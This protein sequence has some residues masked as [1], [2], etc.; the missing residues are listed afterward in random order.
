[1]VAAIRERLFH[2]DYPT[3]LKEEAKREK[4]TIFLSIS[5]STIYGEGYS[6]YAGSIHT[7]GYKLDTESFWMANLLLIPSPKRREACAKKKVPKD[8]IERQGKVQRCK[9]KRTVGFS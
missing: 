5:I 7:T 9:G 1:M 8:V 2:V 6:P 3:R 4:A